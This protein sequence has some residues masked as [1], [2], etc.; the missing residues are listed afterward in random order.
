MPTADLGAMSP[1]TRTATAQ[2][3]G[4]VKH[5]RGGRLWWRDRQHP[6]RL[7]ES[8]SNEVGGFN[9]TTFGCANGGRRLVH[10]EI[11][12]GMLIV[13]HGL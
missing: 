2:L 12:R 7:S 4:D 13:G 6:S 8:A 9:P 11:V 3:E 1:L 10:V 5:E